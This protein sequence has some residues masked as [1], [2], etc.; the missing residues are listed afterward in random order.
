[1][2][3][4]QQPTLKWRPPIGKVVVDYIRKHGRTKRA[5]LYK[6]LP[7]LERSIR[8]VVNDKLKEGILKEEPCECGHTGFI[9]MA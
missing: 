5:D 3:R 7:F 6:S 8:V 9:E 2:S 1:M 4:S